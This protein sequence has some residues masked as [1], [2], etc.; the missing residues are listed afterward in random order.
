MIVKQFIINADDGGICES[1]NR[2]I[3]TA[4]R[5]G[6]LTSASIMANGSAF[7]HALDTIV[8]PNP[9]LGVGI[10]LCLTN[11]YSV[12]SPGE[13]PLL[14]DDGGRFRHGFVSLARIA[15]LPAARK[16]IESEVDAQFER[17]ESSAIAIDHA[18]SHRHV[19][20]IP[21]ILR[22]VGRLVQRRPGCFL[23]IAREPLFGIR[24]TAVATRWLALLQNLPKVLLLNQLARQAIGRRRT[25]PFVDRTFGILGSGNMDYPMLERLITHAPEGRSEIIMHPGERATDIPPE[26]GPGDCKFLNS[27]LR[28]AELEALTDPQLHRL[29]DRLGIEFVRFCDV[30]PPASAGP[31][32]EDEAVKAQEEIVRASHR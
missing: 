11:G 32:R 20:M 23:R 18:D 17:M 3:A 12:L 7:E 8:S 9:K 27:P 15:R 25:F 30:V 13:V 2:A 10:H 29:S 14:V 21:S 5:H 1:T 16:Q 19:H 28:L 4:F 24:Q 22:I 6:L 31:G 26:T